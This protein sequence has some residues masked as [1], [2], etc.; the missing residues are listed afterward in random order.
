MKRTSIVH[1]ALAACIAQSFVL[2]VPAHAQTEAA[3]TDLAKKKNVT[4]P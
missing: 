2:A 4:A 3:S 1:A